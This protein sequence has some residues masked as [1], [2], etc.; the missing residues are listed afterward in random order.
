MQ[1]ESTLSL[2]MEWLGYD[3]IR[4][5][6]KEE[7]ISQRSHRDEY[8]ANG[9][10]THADLEDQQA[11]FRDEWYTNAG[12]LE[13][14]LSQLD[15]QLE[16]GQ[17]FANINTLSETDADSICVVINSS[18]QQNQQEV[19]QSARPTIAN[20]FLA[21]DV[22]VSYTQVMSTVETAMTDKNTES[23]G[24]FSETGRYLQNVPHTST[25]ANIN[26]QTISESD[27][28]V[29]ISGLKERDQP[30]SN[31]SGRLTRKERT[32]FT[33]RQLS[34][35]EEEFTRHNYLTRMRRY[36]IAHSLQLTERQVKVWFQNR[37]MKW[38]RNKGTQMC[39]ERPI[40]ILPQRTALT[41]GPSVQWQS[42]QQATPHLQI[43][44]TR[45]T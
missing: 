27:K 35:L 2:N 9:D 11:A 13:G 6:R 19:S 34:A 29:L 32:A 44:N 24:D 33:K 17:L 45:P 25:Q 8:R 42:I 41:L 15:S 16:N 40:G 36:E 23:F 10:E 21:A 3:A 43:N 1:P 20:G 28:L 26:G 22:A 14:I 18:L 30:S 37:R 31:E 7:T 12:Q 39:R 5:T 4:L 38:K